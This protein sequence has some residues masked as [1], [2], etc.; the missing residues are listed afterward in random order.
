[1]SSNV[2]QLNFD[3]SQI[4]N[5]LGSMEDRITNLIEQ[6]KPKS[7]AN[8]PLERAKEYYQKRRMRER[9]FGGAKMFSDPAWDILIDLFIASEEGRGISVSSACIASTVPMTTALRWIKLLEEEGHVV[10]QEDPL[11]A[12]RVYMILTPTAT[13][14]VREYFSN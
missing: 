6:V 10:R 4:A 12:R 8:T 2:E 13:N 11:D 9:M 7:A 1:M 3:S 14:T 5:A